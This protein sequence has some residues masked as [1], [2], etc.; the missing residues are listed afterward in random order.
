M[1]ATI[2]S[3]INCEIRPTK[4]SLGVLNTLVKSSNFNPNP[5]PSIISA[6]MIG[7][8]FVTTSIF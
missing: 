6:R 7:A 4:K 2:G 3:I 5:N 1:Y 8:N